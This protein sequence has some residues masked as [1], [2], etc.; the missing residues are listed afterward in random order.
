V[1]VFVPDGELNVIFPVALQTVP[2]N[3]DIE[4]LIANVP[5]LLNVTVPADTV[6][7]RHVKA[8]VNVTV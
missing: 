8:P 7:S 6:K 3:K 2:A 4:P 5:V 1:I